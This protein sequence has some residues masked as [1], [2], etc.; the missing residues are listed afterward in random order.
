MTNVEVGLDV[1]A[2]RKQGSL[3]GMG[4]ELHVPEKQVC[5]IIN[6]GIASEVSS[7]HES[8]CEP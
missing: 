5:K 2:Q 6:G 7:R 8:I 3:E 1:P 4:V